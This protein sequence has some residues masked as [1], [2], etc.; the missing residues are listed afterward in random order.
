MKGLQ[1]LLLLG[2]PRLYEVCA[3]VV[4]DELPQVVAWVADLDQV[5][6]EI[7]LAEP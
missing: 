4:K 2:D 1:D 5:M 3:P 7:S 6:K